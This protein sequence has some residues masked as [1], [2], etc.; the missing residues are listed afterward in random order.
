METDQEFKNLYDHDG[1]SDEEDG[2]NKRKRRKTY[3]AK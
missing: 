2:N 3:S 1:E